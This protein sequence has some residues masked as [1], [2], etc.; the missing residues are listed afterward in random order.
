MTVTDYFSEA[1]PVALVYILED[2]VLGRAIT[3]VN[4]Y[5]CLVENEDFRG[6]S[7][8]TTDRQTERGGLTENN[9]MSFVR[10]ECLI[11]RLLLGGAGRH[12][13]QTHRGRAEVAYPLKNVKALTA[14]CQGR[15]QHETCF[16]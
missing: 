13:V 8:H 1:I 6:G 9:P 12:S 2:A 14:L 10:G 7:G 11:C 16:L 3:L 4:T 5:S 15:H